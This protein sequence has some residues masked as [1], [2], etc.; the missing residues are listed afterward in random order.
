MTDAE[1]ALLKALWNRGPSTV[2]A[3]RCHGDSRTY[4]TVQTLLL[5][6]EQ[7]GYVR[8]DRS[9]ATHVYEPAVTRDEVLDGRLEALARDLCDGSAAPLLLRLVARS[10]LDA[11]DVAHFRGLLDAPADDPDGPD[12]DRPD[13][14]RLGEED[15]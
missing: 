5:R 7:K 2:R 12:P 14:D 9:L 6:L 13:P 8:V 11:A 15:A 1:Q 3:L 10:G 4:N